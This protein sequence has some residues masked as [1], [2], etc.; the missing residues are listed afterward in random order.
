MLNVSA[1]AGQ[2][3]PVHDL[4]G[5][6]SPPMADHNL[7]EKLIKTSSALEEKAPSSKHASGPPTPSQEA[8]CQ[9][10]LADL[11]RCGRGVL[12]PKGLSRPVAL[13]PW[14][15]EA[16]PGT[17]RRTWPGLLL[18]W[19]ACSCNTMFSLRF[20]SL[21]YLII[22]N[23]NKYLGFGLKYILLLQLCLFS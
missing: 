12:P 23:C 14:W 11:L 2:G 16:F 17:V 15:T 4:M 13:L 18:I 20:L 7:A 9:Q 6:S 5:Q 19:S 1:G 3:G 21:V 10:S 22:K 8:S